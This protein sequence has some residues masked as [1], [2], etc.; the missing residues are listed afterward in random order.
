MPSYPTRIG[1]VAIL[2]PLAPAELPDA[3][4]IE[5]RNAAVEVLYSDQSRRPARLLNWRQLEGGWA[6][7]LRWPD[8]T[9]DWR[10]YDGR[11]IRPIA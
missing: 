8:R 10:V 5:P 9:E 6:V 3:P 2:K 11:Y 1:T 4:D 7:R